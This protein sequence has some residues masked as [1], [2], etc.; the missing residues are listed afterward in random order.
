MEALENKTIVIVDIDNKKI[1]I[2]AEE[3]E[4]VSNCDINDFNCIKD[5]LTS[6]NSQIT[7]IDLPLHYK[8][9]LSDQMVKYLKMN[10][11]NISNL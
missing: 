9:K 5:N 4:K 11:L 6:Y 8:K 10:L 7:D 3:K 1:E 2:I